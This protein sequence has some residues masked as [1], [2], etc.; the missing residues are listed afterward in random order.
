[1]VSKS[2]S[3]DFDDLKKVRNKK[4]GEL[5]KLSEFRVKRN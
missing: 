3:L 1:M 2:V 4:K 5:A